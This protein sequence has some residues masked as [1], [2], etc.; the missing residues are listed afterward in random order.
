MNIF[1]WH[2]R[3]V[4]WFQVKLK[5]SNYAMLWVAFIEGFL[6][7]IFIVSILVWYFP[8]YCFYIFNVLDWI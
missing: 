5:L 2:K 7:A 3:F 6:V 1:N 4:E 8:I